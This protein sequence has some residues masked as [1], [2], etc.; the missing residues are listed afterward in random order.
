MTTAGDPETFRFPHLA[1]CDGAHATRQRC[2]GVVQEPSNDIV[3]TDPV[4]REPAMDPSFDADEPVEMSVVTEDL[5]DIESEFFA[6]LSSCAARTASRW[7]KTIAVSTCGR[8][9]R[10]RSSFLP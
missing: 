10:L 4:S 7:C 2:R 5:D 3:V 9:F 8:S 1:G 6:E